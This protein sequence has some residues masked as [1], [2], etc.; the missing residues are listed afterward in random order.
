MKVLVALDEFQEDVGG[1]AA[2]F[3][4]FDERNYRKLEKQG[5]NFEL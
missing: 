1:R 3:Y 2:R 5:F 4:R